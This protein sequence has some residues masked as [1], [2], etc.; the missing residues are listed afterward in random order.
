MST[1]S[2][3]QAMGPATKRRLNIENALSQSSGKSTFKNLHKAMSG[4]TVGSMFQSDKTQT[5]LN[6]KISPGGTTM[7]RK[8]G[9]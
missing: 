9:Y 6:G 5:A 1:L 3:E 4:S 2:A 7:I 8:E